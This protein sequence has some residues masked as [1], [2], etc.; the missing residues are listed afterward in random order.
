MKTLGGSKM[1]YKENIASVE[2][3]KYTKKQEIFNTITHQLGIPVA[4]VI[5]VF[6]LVQFIKG[7]ISPSYFLGLLVFVFTIIDVY[8]VSSLYHSTP[9]NCFNKKVFRVLDHCSI[10]LL[11]A[12]TYTPICVVLMTK[13]VVGLVM[14]IVEWG[15]AFIGI[16]LNAFLFK[17]KIA[18]IIS[19]FL[20]LGMGW[21][22]LFCGGF[23]YMTPLSFGFVLAGGI[24]YSLG[25]LIYAIGKKN[26]NL[27]GVFHIFVLFSTIVQSIGVLSLF[28]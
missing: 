20:Y 1:S 25:C 23:I 22:V 7:I 26:L 3:P 6:G 9:S 18:Q 27:H 14:L 17:N 2:I 24:I 5:F 13:N 21:L 16:L 4:I 8:F 28:I 19:L 10:Y 11:I 15:L 12:G